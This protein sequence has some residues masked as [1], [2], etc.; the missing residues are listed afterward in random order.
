MY[1]SIPKSIGKRIANAV[2]GHERSLLRQGHDPR[3]PPILQQLPV[4][5]VWNQS[6]AD[7]PI[8][9]VLGIDSPAWPPSEDT[10]AQ[11]DFLFRDGLVV[12][13]P[14]MT[15]HRGRWVVLSEA[16]PE[17]GRGLA[18]V[19]G[20]V[21]V[22]VF[23]NGVEDQYCDVIEGV[24]D[25]DATCYL[26][27]GASGARILWRENEGSGAETVVWAIV[28]LGTEN[29]LIPIILKESLT[30]GGNA[31]AYVCKADW[32]IIDESTPYTIRVRDT[33]GDKRALGKDDLSDDPA[34]G[35]AVALADGTFAILEI[36]Q[37]AKRIAGTLGG[38]LT[39]TTAS[40]TVD[41]PVAQDGGQIPSGTLTAYNTKTT[42]GMSGAIG[43]VCRA[44]WNETTVHYE[45]YYVE[46]VAQTVVTNEQITTDTFKFQKKT[47]SLVGWWDGDE[48]DW[49]DVHTGTNTC[50]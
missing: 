36:R 19:H 50:P 6:G 32:T 39:T 12:V 7:Q 13:E 24:A 17:G 9:A 5:P 16:I 34:K 42:K 3:Q 48:S 2:K 35:Y 8:N 28:R 41:T 18:W 11:R 22:R 38:A 27:T 37:Q 26:G 21:R 31:D 20:V 25:G 43:N 29:G 23:V 30:P 40:Q 45:F 49:A 47:R 46:G 33:I 14:T 44:E 4:W 1:T 10:A 15:D